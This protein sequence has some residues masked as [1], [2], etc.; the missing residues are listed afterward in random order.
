VAKPGQESGLKEVKRNKQAN[1]FYFSLMKSSKNHGPGK[2]ALKIFAPSLN[3]PPPPSPGQIF[4]AHPLDFL[5]ANFNGPEVYCFAAH[6]ACNI[7][8]WQRITWP[9][10]PNDFERARNLHTSVIPECLY[11]ESSTPRV[12]ES[13]VAA[14]SRDITLCVSFRT[15]ISSERGIESPWPT[16]RKHIWY[17]SEASQIKM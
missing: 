8:I 10:I 7:M 12:H 14:H 9:V 6:T 3:L 1:Y 15:T 2:I 4:N 13:D 17:C 16:A 5:N 11:R